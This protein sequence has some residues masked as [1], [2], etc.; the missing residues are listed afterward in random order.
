MKCQF[1][2]SVRQ[3]IDFSFCCFYILTSANLQ[4]HLNITGIYFFLFFI[5]DS[6]IK[7]LADSVT[8]AGRF[9]LFNYLIVPIGSL[10]RLSHRRGG[11][12]GRKQ[13]WVWLVRYELGYQTANI[14]NGQ[15]LCNSKINAKMMI[16]TECQPFYSISSI[17]WN[18]LVLLQLYQEL[19]ADI[20]LIFH[21][22]IYLVLE[23]W[24]LID[25]L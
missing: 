10:T 4:A 16:A 1:S 3:R 22:F 23:F 7:N 20:L 11:L 2:P 14:A 19:V 9:T 21:W 24:A 5:F 8:A 15:R 13:T 6:N 18:N 12:I 17:Q 25:L